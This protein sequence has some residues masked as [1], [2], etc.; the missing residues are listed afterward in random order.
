MIIQN[1]ISFLILCVFTT[2]TV[3]V[4]VKVNELKPQ[5]IIQKEKVYIVD[6]IFVPTTNMLKLQ[7][8]LLNAEAGGEGLIGQ[9][10][11]GEVVS[12]RVVNKSMSLSEV[13]F[14]PYQFCGAKS[15]RFNL[16]PSVSCYLASM[17]SLSGSNI[18]PENIEHFANAAIA[19]DK[20]WINHPDTK[21][22]RKN[23]KHTFYEVN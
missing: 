4:A 3:F 10:L 13:I 23:G 9:I 1:L 5:V 11:C 18:L 12:N 8:K 19:T 6:T 14:K 15:R 22:I 21:V 2:F 17:L 20:S 7:A 16:T